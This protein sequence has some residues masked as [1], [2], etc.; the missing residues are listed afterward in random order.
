[1]VVCLSILFFIDNN[2]YHYRHLLEQNSNHLVLEIL[3]LENTG[4]AKI[5]IF[6]IK[7]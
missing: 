6:N 1:M 3:L 2:K 4:D 7:Y 5:Q